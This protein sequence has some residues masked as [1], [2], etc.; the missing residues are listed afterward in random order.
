MTGDTDRGRPLPPGALGALAAA[1][2]AA[3]GARPLAEKVLHGS[4]G[5]PVVPLV[6]TVP[7]NPG[8]DVTSSV[9]ALWLALAFALVVAATAEVAK[10]GCVRRR[11]LGLYLWALLFQ[12]AATVETFASCAPDWAAY[13]WSGLVFQG[14]REV[15]YTAMPRWPAV[16]LVILLVLLAR[17]AWTRWRSAPARRS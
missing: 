3:L 5:G 17:P 9:R 16:S 14:R 8:N 15:W 4:V 12:L 13:A 2:G 7:W 10:S 1:W 6:S 11:D